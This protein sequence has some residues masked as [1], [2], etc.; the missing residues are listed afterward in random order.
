MTVVVRDKRVGAWMD[1]ARRFTHQSFSL[2]RTHPVLVELRAEAKRATDTAEPAR[3]IALCHFRGLSQLG[4]I[5]DVQNAQAS[6]YPRAG[7]SPNELCVQRPG[8]RA[9]LHGYVR[10]YPPD[11]TQPGLCPECVE[12]AAVLQ[13]QILAGEIT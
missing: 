13:L 5:R 4:E 12:R 11:F 9:Y 7:W 3:H 10:P 8:E 6:P 2:R 1:Y